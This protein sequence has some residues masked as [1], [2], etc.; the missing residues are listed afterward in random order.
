MLP[1]NPDSAICVQ[2]FDDSLNFAIRTTYR[3]LLRSSS[4]REPRDPPL[5]VVS[6]LIFPSIKTALHTKIVLKC[7][8]TQIKALQQRSGPASYFHLCK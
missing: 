2:R 3:T 7:V 1:R 6:Y 4:I 5:K 8:H